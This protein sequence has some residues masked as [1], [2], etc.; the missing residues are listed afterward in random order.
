MTAAVVPVKSLG[1][2]K[3]RLLPELSRKHLEAL[4]LAM[5]EDLLGALQATPSLI[6]VAV[7]TPDDRVA[8]RTRELG[9][10]ALHG[11]DDGL[12][13]ALDAAAGK[14]GLSEDAP[15][16][17]VLGDIPGARS[18]EL[19]ALFATLAEMEPG[20]AVVLAASGDGGTSAL[21]RRPHSAIPSQFGPQS[22]ARHREGA[23][24]AGVPLRELELPSLATDLDC[25]EDLERF[26]AEESAGDRTRSFLKDL[27]WTPG[28]PP[29]FA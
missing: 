8:E 9:A 14:M 12:N 21:L 10:E 2:G 29:K 17:V 3:S 23:A 5:L 16:L 26:L 7:A 18:E 1:A 20:P 19:E 24:A 28:S 4:S 22:A 11:P 15:L 13:S 27:G 25:R 6:R